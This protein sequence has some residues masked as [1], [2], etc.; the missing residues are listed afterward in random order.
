MLDE[1]LVGAAIAFAVAV[2]TTPVGVSGAVFLVPVQVSVLSVPSPAVT[3]TNLLYNLVAIPGA[4]AQFHRAG[5]LRG[6]LVRL[7]VLGTLPGVVAGAVIRVELLSGPEAFYL[8]IAAVLAP[9]GAWLAL[10][11]PARPGER[12]RLTDHQVVALALAV[13]TIGGIY[14]IGGGSILAPILAGVG[15]G[16]A[17]VAPATLAATFLT[18]IA[19]VAT[20][21]LL[22]L[23][24]PGDIA[25]EWGIGIA[26]GA[27][28][29]AGGLA[30]LRLA[31]RLPEPLLR[32][33]LGILALALGARYAVLGLA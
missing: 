17:E 6:S 9:L 25:P 22:S 12:P 2:V 5:R 33:G 28:G 31:P 26:I 7:L 19:G 13:G 14:G 24:E 11:G 23:T 15:F 30:G 20:Y 32:R 1:A 4:L 18:S 10:G 8:V 21:A 27:G 16:I 29:L 3:P